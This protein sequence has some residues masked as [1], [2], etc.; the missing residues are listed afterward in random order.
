VSSWL[1]VV[2]G[3]LRDRRL[4]PVT[5]AFLGFSAAEYGAWVALLV[6]AYD[7]GGALAS[8]LV[9][10]VQL[11]PCAVT[12]P[13]AAYAGDRFR[14][15][16]VLLTGYA[17]QSAT[18]LLTGVAVLG[19]APPILVY[20][21]ALA[22]SVSLTSTRP[23]HY[24]F[25]PDITPSVEMLTAANSVS[26]LAEG[27][28]MLLG[29]LM[30]GVLLASLGVAS[31]F[32]AFAM[33]SLGAALLVAR[34]RAGSAPSR[35][36][37]ARAGDV[38]REALRGFG[39][40]RAEPSVGLPIAAL[41]A[42]AVLAGALDVLFVAT[43]ID[44]LGA[45]AGWAGYL[46]A[47]LGLGGIVGA[48]LAVSLAGRGRLTPALAAGS[49]MAGA[50]I[51]AIGVVPMMATAPVLV[52]LSGAGRSLAA[53][54]GNTLLQRAAPPRIMARVFGVLESVTMLALA[55]G[56]LG[57]SSLVALAGI[58]GALVATGAFVP[59]VVAALWRPLRA[60][61]RTAKA[62]D[63]ALV[64]LVRALPMF[65]PLPAPALE[66][67]LASLQRV[68]LPAGETL[69]REGDPG[70]RC[71]ILAAGDADIIQHGE[72]VAVRHGVDI[73]GEIALLRDI[74]RIATVV[75]ATPLELYALDR[76]PFLEAV[77]GHPGARAR[78]DE[79]V[80]GRIAGRS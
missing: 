63:P 33:A 34:A 45:G 31:V 65:A 2:G 51:A 30:A 74:P 53:V 75:A 76:E 4:L 20:A 80:D 61:E 3:V 70:D 43:A 24:A 9:A 50:P 36:D 16:R 40:V 55:V 73:L 1:R 28:G 64:A 39:V 67:I 6:Y 71:F 35:P 10:V 37:E 26:G 23:T 52:G 62:P 60:I 77:T 5:A 68:D 49:A 42:T 32:V 11:V 66:R 15:E 69:M 46:S 58:S 47:A 18:L 19:G 29:P 13:F 38:V 7:H 12:A 57:A 48:T 17:A 72:R 22:A 27:V 25:L 14:R 41:A 54:A 44:L 78:A 56:S 8:G 59:L 79:V 21:V